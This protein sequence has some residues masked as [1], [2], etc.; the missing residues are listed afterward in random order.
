[1]KTKSKLIQTCL[2]LAMLLPVAV[3]AQFTFTTNNGAITITGFTGSGAAVIPSTT[4][5]YPVTMIG[6]SAFAGSGLTSVTIP[7]SVTNIGALAFSSCSNLSSL[8]IPKSVTGMGR[9]LC[10]GSTNLQAITVDAQNPSY[11]SSV[12]GVLF[13][14]SQFQLI[15]CL[16]GKQRSYKVPDTVTNIVGDAFHFCVN[17]TSITVGKN[18]TSVFS[19]AFAS[20]SNLTAVYFKG[21][22]PSIVVGSDLFT[23]VSI[24]TVYYLPGTTGWHSTFGTPPGQRPTTLWNPQAPT[25]DGSFGV[26]TNQFGFNITGSSNLVIVVEGCTNLFNPVWL[27]LGTNTLNTF[28]G[29]NGTSYFS[30]PHWTNYPGR[31]YRLRSP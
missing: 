4:N 10:L 19:W 30:D 21:N 29:T 2:L 13:D 31:F 28:I 8:I 1:M 18:V 16:G 25:G 14:K 24:A 12:D 7:E 26:R 6:I 11:S 20:C 3:R 17:L 23:G 5:G 15:E 22:A 27:S 9:E